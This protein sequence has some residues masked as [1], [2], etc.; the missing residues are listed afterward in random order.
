MMRV[1]APDALLALD[2]DGTPA[3][4]VASPPA[5]AMRRLGDGVRHMEGIEVVNLVPAGAPTK[6]DALARLRAEC[7]ASAVF[8]IGDEE[9][10]EDAF[11]VLDDDALLAVRVEYSDTSRARY[12]VPTQSDVEGLLDLVLVATTAFDIRPPDV[13]RQTAHGESAGQEGRAAPQARVDA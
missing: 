7:G 12:F 11:T 2:F 3:P 6:G 1:V 10:D 8:H 9:T 5:A 13:A 4:I